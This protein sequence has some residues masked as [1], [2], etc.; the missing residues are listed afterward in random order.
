MMN[1]GFA[2]AGFDSA[3]PAGSLVP[4]AMRSP[5]TVEPEQQRALGAW[6][7]YNEPG[8][9]CDRGTLGDRPFYDTAHGAIVVSYLS[10]PDYGS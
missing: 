8:S 5:T 10:S 3:Q 9:P 6:R 4:Y 1:T 7:E 2:S